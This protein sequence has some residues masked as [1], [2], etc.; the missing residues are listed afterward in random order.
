MRRR[1]V[2]V[3]TDSHVQRRVADHLSRKGFVVQTLQAPDTGPEELLAARGR[4]KPASAVVLEFPQPDG[5]GAELIHALA[6][7]NP[8]PALLALC[9]HGMIEAGVAALKEGADDY[10]LAPFDPEEL[11]LKLER[12]LEQRQLREGLERMRAVQLPARP[13]QRELTGSS[14]LIGK[15]RKRIALVARGSATVLITGETGT[16]KELAATAIHE[17]SPRRHRRI[18]KVNCAAL[19]DPLLESELFGYERGAFTG[20]EQRRIGR[21]EEA[22]QGTI[23]LDEVGDMQVRTQAKVLRALQEQEFERLGGTRPIRVDVRV[24]AA[25]NQDLRELI[26][27]GRFREDLFFRLNVVPIELPPLRERREDIP[28]LT[29][30]YL[31]EFS[32][33]SPWGKPRMTPRCLEALMAYAWP[34]NVRELCNTLERAVLMSESDEIDV[35]DLGLPSPAGVI[36]C[37]SGG[38]ALV[39]R[40]PEGG[41]DHRDVERELILQALER[42]GWVQKDAAR[43]LHMSR[44]KLNY[45]IQ[46]LG[47]SHPGWR[48]NRARAADPAEE[49]PDIC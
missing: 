22:H 12:A 17:A 10:L 9:P 14:P 13:P 41:V 28:E 1:V 32:A 6:P 38:E 11:E 46:R 4:G 49:D 16:G 33:G 37:S 39:L 23:F 20:A 31:E 45:R 7:V 42:T 19:P 25:T 3:T 36:A 29:E 48:R 35:H 15:V 30:L 5:R 2:L 18:V 8:R 34:G 21:F 27:R 43:L 40:L 47:I 44:R 26:A 24:I